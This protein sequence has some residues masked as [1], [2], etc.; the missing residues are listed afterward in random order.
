MSVNELYHLIRTEECCLWIG[1]G[2]SLTAGY[3]SALEL[4]TLLFQ[5]LNDEE[6]KHIP[7]SSSLADFCL[8]YKTIKGRDELVLRLQEIFGTLSEKTD[9]HILLSKIAHFKSIITTNYDHLIEDSY[10]SSE[11]VVIKG[12][13]DVPDLTAN[14]VKIYKIHGDIED[15]T[16][17]VITRQDY[18]DQYNRDFKDPFWASIIHE[19]SSKHVIFLGYG[20]EDENIWAD[21]D[22]IYRK[23]NGKQKK[24]FMVGPSFTYIKRRKLENLRIAPIAMTGYDFL[25]GLIPVLK[26][27]LAADL[28]HMLV[29]PDIAIQFARNFGVDLRLGSTSTGIDVLSITKATGITEHTVTL[30]II[31]PGVIENF[32]KF[33]ESYDQLKLDI[34]QEHLNKFSMTSAG[35]EI[36]D[37]NFLH[38]FRV[39]HIPSS[40]G[41]CCIEF[42]NIDKEITGVNYKLY[43]NIQ[44]KLLLDIRYFNFEMKI[45]A[46]LHTTDIEVNLDVTEP[47]YGTRVSICVQFYEALCSFLDGERMLIHE[48]ETKPV[49]FHFTESRNQPIFSVRLKNFILLRKLEKFF[50]VRFQNV[51]TMELRKQSKK[52]LNNLLSVAENG[53]FVLEDAGGVDFNDLS[54]KVNWLQIVE[55]GFPKDKWVIFSVSQPMIITVFGIPINLGFFEVEMYEPNIEWLDASKSSILLK[56]KDDTFVFRFLKYGKSPFKETEIPYL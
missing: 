44:G 23:L 17:M 46:Y 29:S 53:V 37:L 3:P 48:S 49:N 4:Q 18:S 52:D 27:H 45:K 55:N 21:F 35:F 16:S 13:T 25:R 41:T 26:K 42:P 38:E 33:G 15:G 10:P 39:M 56:T 12:D 1:A 19:I 34:S 11:R 51:S 5:D 31:D 14:K 24:R 9:Q 32:T 28:R 6:K 30:Q 2:F 50:K 36:I 22:H 47:E 40:E 7:T 54:A 43:N 20:Y 8:D